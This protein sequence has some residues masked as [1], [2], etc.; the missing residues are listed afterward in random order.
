MSSVF[1]LEIF[2]FKETRDYLE[3]QLKFIFIEVPASKPFKL[4]RETL[5][6]EHDRKV[7]I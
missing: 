7:Q 4:T 5:R 3:G 1:K 2:W 6:L